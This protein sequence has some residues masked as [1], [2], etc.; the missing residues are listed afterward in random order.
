MKVTVGEVRKAVREAM[1]S[2]NPEYMVKERIREK[3]QLT[4][5]K[6]VATGKVNDQKTLE[7]KFDVVET[8][9]C[10]DPSISDVVVMA[11]KA[12]RMIPFDVW[13]RMAEALPKK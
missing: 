9:A 8:N 11:M 10:N 4:I 12:L 5:T 13:K 7:K 3:L 6:A 1:V 2:A